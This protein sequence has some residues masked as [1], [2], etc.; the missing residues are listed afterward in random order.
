MKNVSITFKLSESEKE[1]IVQEAKKRDIPV[2]QLI[3]E[4]IKEYLSK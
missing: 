4:I 3:R 1:R 2:S